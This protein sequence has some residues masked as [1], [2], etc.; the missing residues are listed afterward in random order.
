[1]KFRGSIWAVS[2]ATLGTCAMGCT[3][4]SN[5]D[6]LTTTVEAAEQG[7][8]DAQYKL[9]YRF[10]HGDIT[11][12][13][14]AEATKWFTEAAEGDADAQYEL[15]DRYVRGDVVAQDFA[16]AARWFRKAAEQGSAN[17]QYRLGWMYVDGDGVETDVAK[18][19]RWYTAA[20]EQ[21]HMDAQLKLGM[22][23]VGRNKEEAV[24]WLT[25]AAEVGDAAAA[26]RLGALHYY[27]GGSESVK[28]F[29][30]VDEQ[31]GRAEAQLLLGH[32]YL[33]GAGV[34]KD[35]EEAIIWLTGGAVQDNSR[36]QFTLG[37]LYA[38]EGEVRD[39]VQAYM[40]F[41]MAAEALSYAKLARDALE[42]KMSKDEV[43][44][45][46]RR[47]AALKAREI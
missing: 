42:E 19:I 27:D 26:L 37:F 14:F 8:E 45:A 9:G 13:D 1:M 4:E 18:A 24:R 11:E 28:W 12:Q 39:L 38:H 22:L 21:G 31:G 23:Y 17:A 25:T 47:E 16:E 29:I 40:W 6:Q 5:P 41:D 43:A 10:V 2:V 46:K 36:A 34:E 7:T 32:L 3:P 30:K 35:V 20:A 44:A 33:G 15:G